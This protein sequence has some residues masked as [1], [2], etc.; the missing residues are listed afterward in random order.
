MLGF[1]MDDLVCLFVLFLFAGG[2]PDLAVPDS[3]LRGWMARRGGAG[4]LQAVAIALQRD[5][6][7]MHRDD[8]ATASAPQ[9]RVRQRLPT[10]PNVA[11]FWRARSRLYRSRFLQVTS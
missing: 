6:N 7:V 11:K 1:E 4:G 9:D 3:L 8:N 5:A 2:C 10:A